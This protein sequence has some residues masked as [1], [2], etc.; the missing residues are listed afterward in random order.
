MSRRPVHVLAVLDFAALVS[1]FIIGA[2]LWSYTYGV[3]WSAISGPITFAVIPL[4]A[5]LMFSTM[6][7][8]MP[9]EEAR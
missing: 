1:A 4:F 9:L 6:V 7:R 3:E 8:V 2:C 5:S